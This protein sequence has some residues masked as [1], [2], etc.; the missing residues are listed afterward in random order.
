NPW[1]RRRKIELAELVNEPWALPPPDSLLGSVAVEAFRAKGLDYP[2]ATVSSAPADVRISLLST[3]RLLAMCSRSILL[4][5]TKRLD[6]RVLPVKLRVARVPMGVVPLKNRMLSPAA[7]LF[8]EVARE[9]AKPLAGE[10]P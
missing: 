9:V 5:P 8:I 7:K 1:A 6:I 3:G 2:R 4:F 10:R